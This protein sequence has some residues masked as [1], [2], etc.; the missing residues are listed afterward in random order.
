MRHLFPVTVDDGTDVHVNAS[1]LPYFLPL[2]NFVVCLIFYPF[3]NMFYFF[4][5]PFLITF[6]F[7]IIKK[8]HFKNF[9]RP[10]INRFATHQFGKRCCIQFAI[11]IVEWDTSKKNVIFY[12]RLWAVWTG[13]YQNEIRPTILNVYPNNKCSGC[14][15]SMSREDK[16]G[17]GDVTVSTH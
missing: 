14:P 10:T 16:C 15:F 17:Q 4:T 9:S 1:Y 7:Y 3:L 11:S 13:I 8:S 2:A 6:N 5:F 12:L